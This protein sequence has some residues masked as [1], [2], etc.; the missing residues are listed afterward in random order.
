LEVESAVRIINS[1][2]YKPR[3]RFVAS[4]NTARFEGG[5][6]VRIHYPAYQSERSDAPRYG[7]RIMTSATFAFQCL[8]FDDVEVY[9]TVLRFVLR[10]E[11]HEAREFLRV[12]PTMWAPFHPHRQ[13]GMHRWGNPES[14]L[15]FGIG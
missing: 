12:R 15:M 13:G 10:I 3:W 4:D 1:L 11:E 9:R 8:D 7:T 6:L 2:V 14:D 5:V